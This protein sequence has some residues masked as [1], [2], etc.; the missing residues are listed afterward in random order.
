[1]IIRAF[2][3]LYAGLTVLVMDPGYWTSRPFWGVIAL[4]PTPDICTGVHFGEVT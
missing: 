2:C 4:V 1:M 3:L